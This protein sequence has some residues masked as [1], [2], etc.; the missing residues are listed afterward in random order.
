MDTTDAFCF[1]ESAKAFFF[2]GGMR[3]PSGICVPFAGVGGFNQG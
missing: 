3:M 2:A 1:M